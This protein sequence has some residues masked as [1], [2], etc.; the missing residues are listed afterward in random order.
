MFKHTL[1]RVDARKRNAKLARPRDVVV[2]AGIQPQNRVDLARL[3][4][5]Y[6]DRLMDL[7]LLQQ[8]ARIASIHIWQVD[9]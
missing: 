6:Q 3:S 9:V 4:G 5:E 2:R 1:L 8:P 7:A